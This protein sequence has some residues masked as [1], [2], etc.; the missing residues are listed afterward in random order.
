M[1]GVIATKPRPGAQTE[2]RRAK[3]ER[4]KLAAHIIFANGA[5]G[6]ECV[7]TELSAVGARLKLPLNITSLDEF[8]QRR[9][10][11]VWSRGETIGV[12]FELDVAEKQP[13]AASDLAKLAKLEAENAKL[14]AKIA[15]LLAE[16]HRLTDE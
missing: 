13:V 10:R 8:E 2:S 16:F 12:K 7:V 1:T 5:L 4:V 9:A 3:R 14:Q 11:V 15:E 6:V